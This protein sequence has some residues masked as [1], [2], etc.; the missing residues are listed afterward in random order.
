MT[1]YGNYYQDNKCENCGSKLTEEE[2]LRGHKCDKKKLRKQLWASIYNLSRMA[3]III[4]ILW[5]MFQYIV[6][7]I[8]PDNFYVLVLILLV[9]QDKEYYGN[10]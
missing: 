10:T 7:G 5:I 4:G 3:V 6:R 8:D 1:Q 2:I 9:L